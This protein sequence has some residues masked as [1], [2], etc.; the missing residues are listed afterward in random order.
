MAFLEY[1]SLQSSSNVSSSM[2]HESFGCCLYRLY[3]A[4][5]LH[6]WDCLPSALQHPLNISGCHEMYHVR[7]S[8]AENHWQNRW[9]K[10]QWMI[11]DS[12]WVTDES[13]V[14]TS[15]ILFINICT[16]VAV[17]SGVC[18]IFN[19]PYGLKPLLCSRNVS[20]S[21]MNYTLEFIW[22]S[23]MCGSSPLTFFTQRFSC[24]VSCRNDTC[25]TS[26][27]S[28]WPSYC[29]TGTA[30]GLCRVQKPPPS[31]GLFNTFHSSVGM[32]IFLRFAPST[33]MY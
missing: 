29:M 12:Q 26:C 28:Y 25:G 10:A 22:R 7:R 30:S 16:G 15:L 20:L 13:I 5:A 24:L 11:H 2:S 23:S 33:N 18:N 9:L 17:A 3:C 1:P 27:A 4:A 31:A 14:Q 21:W 32:D 8:W 19:F 6:P